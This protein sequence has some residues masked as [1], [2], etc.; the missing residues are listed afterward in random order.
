MITGSWSGAVGCQILAF[1]RVHRFVSLRMKSASQQSNENHWRKL[2]C[3]SGELLVE[4]N[5]DV[6]C[7]LTWINVATQD[8][9]DQGTCSKRVI[10]LVCLSQVPL[11]AISQGECHLPSSTLLLSLDI[12]PCMVWGFVILSVQSRIF[13]KNVAIVLDSNALSALT[14]GF[15]IRQC[16]IVVQ[17]I[18]FA[19]D[20]YQ[21]RGLNVATAA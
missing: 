7:I 20:G 9:P 19:S 6:G 18:A 12:G 16:S 13:M 17:S 1:G 10:V 2:V 21:F 15:I 3:G 8:S 11:H 14:G 4:I 5:Y